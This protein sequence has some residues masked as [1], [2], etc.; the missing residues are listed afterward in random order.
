MKETSVSSYTVCKPLTQDHRRGVRWFSSLT[1]LFGT[2]Y[3]VTPSLGHSIQF[4]SAY[5]E[6][7]DERFLGMAE[8][9]LKYSLKTAKA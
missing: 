1:S 6:T 2:Q 7:G 3:E 4:Y 5:A 8:D 9:F